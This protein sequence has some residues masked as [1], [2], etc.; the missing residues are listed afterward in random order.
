[1][2]TNA[3]R[4]IGSLQPGRWIADT[5]FGGNG[6]SWGGRSINKLVDNHS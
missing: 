5:T 4:N 1:M 3:C 6:S 2:K